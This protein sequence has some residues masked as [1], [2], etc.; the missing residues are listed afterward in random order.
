MVE[1][2]INL[3]IDDYERNILNRFEIINKNCQDY[4]RRVEEIGKKAK[5]K[6]DEYS[7][8]NQEMKWKE[9]EEALVEVQNGNYGE[10][11]RIV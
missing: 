10:N 11:L 5:E 4:K 7:N 6:Y 2:L 1:E 9:F 3:S 8:G